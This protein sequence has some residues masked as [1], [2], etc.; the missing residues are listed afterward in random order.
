MWHGIALSTNSFSFFSSPSSTKK[1]KKKEANF[2][3]N[4]KIW[5]V[6]YLNANSCFFFFLLFIFFCFTSFEFCRISIEF[7]L[8]IK[9]TER[10]KE[11]KKWRDSEWDWMS[12]SISCFFLHSTHHSTH[13]NIAYTYAQASSK[14]INNE[15]PFM[16]CRLYVCNAFAWK[17]FSL[18]F[19]RYLS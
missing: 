11:G 7:V 19:F 3:A 1:K 14:T 4:S 18:L 9:F 13:T 10:K 17:K 8:K 5:F 12:E 15:S 6:V 2:Q 16:R